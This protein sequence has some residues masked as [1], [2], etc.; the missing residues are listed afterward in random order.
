M[1]D[2]GL[3]SFGRKDA[4]EG[5]DIRGIGSEVG[6]GPVLIKRQLVPGVE[7]GRVQVH[8]GQMPGAEV[9]GDSQKSRQQD[10]SR[11]HWDVGSSCVEASALQKSPT[12][13]L[14]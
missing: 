13:R 12:C 7:T 9:I 6:A 3:D 4:G 11:S 8:G 5:R 10:F 1:G 14:G 2:R